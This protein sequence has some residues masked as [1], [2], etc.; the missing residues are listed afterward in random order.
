[1]GHTIGNE[2]PR[3]KLRGIEKQQGNFTPMQASRNLL[4]ELILEDKR[5][6]SLRGISEDA[7][8]ELVAVG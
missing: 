7:V 5:Q 8:S 3:S 4:I 2:L 1:M 6:D